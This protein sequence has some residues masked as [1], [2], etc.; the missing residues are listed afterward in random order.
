[1]QYLTV[2]TIAEWGCL[3]TGVICLSKD[4]D[5]V[6]RYFPIYLLITCL[7]ETAGI[8]IREQLHRPNT[9]LYNGY[10][11][12]ECL[13][14]STFLYHQLK[15][16]GVKVGVLFGVLALLL[17]GFVAEITGIG[18]MRYANRVTTLM[19]VV[20][21]VASLYYYYLILKEE[22]YVQLGTYAPFWWMSGTLIFYFGGVA[23]FV[24]FEYLVQDQ[25]PHSIHYS[26]RY[27]IFKV[28]NVLLYSCWSYAFICR[29]RLRK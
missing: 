16:Y 6:W 22:E 3:L 1:M 11:V 7:T 4:K 29:F 14:I 17:T 24:F 21:V 5:P 9:P 2:N 27:L 28:L 8:Y 15:P 19:S 23:T 12:V 25:V 18:F 26:V 20:F 10:L 13:T